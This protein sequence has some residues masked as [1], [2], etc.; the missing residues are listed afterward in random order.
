MKAFL[1]SSGEST[2]ACS[3][4]LSAQMLENRMDMYVA[5]RHSESE[6]DLTN[7]KA[8]Q[9]PLC[10]RSGACKYTRYTACLSE[11]RPCSRPSSCSCPVL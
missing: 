2:R 11:A 10:I 8:S 1:P 6:C 4:F 7:S 5:S 9:T 3:D